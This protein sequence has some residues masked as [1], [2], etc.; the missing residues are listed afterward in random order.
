MS[1]SRIFGLVVALAIATVI[2]VNAPLL[3]GTGTAP[4]PRMPASTSVSS[5]QGLRLDLSLSATEIAPWQPLVIGVSEFNT[6]SLPV[7]ITVGRSWA[8]EGL[9]MTQCYA[10]I[11]P[12]GVAVYQ[13]RYI[14]S[15]V[16]EAKPLQTFPLVV[17]HMLIRL[18]T[19]YY[20][21]PGG[22][23]AV[24]LPGTG[25]AVP[26]VASATIAG[27]Y[28]TDTLGGPAHPLAPGV[29]TVVAGDEW[30]TLAFLHFIVS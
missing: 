3:S 29:Y 12:F 6:L 10:S 30:G 18:V 21:S 27:T 22:S 15:N 26:M 11:Y 24:V 7:N 1:S 28:S 2:F 16:S 17:C 23:N 8:V 5:V 25:P 9:R 13:G 19:G 20:F 4:P 14:A